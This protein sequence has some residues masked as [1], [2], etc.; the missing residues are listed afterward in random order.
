MGDMGLGISGLYVNIHLA[1]IRLLF[2]DF[3]LGFLYL[4][5]QKAPQPS[6]SFLGPSLNVDDEDYV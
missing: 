5:R 3:P 6:I 1:T 4:S 2:L